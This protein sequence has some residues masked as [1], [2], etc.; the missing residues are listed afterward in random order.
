MLRSSSFLCLNLLSLFILGS[1]FCYLSASAYNIIPYPKQLI[2][3]LGSFSINKRTVV[4]CS[5]DNPEVLKLA[6]QFK[7]QFNLVSGMNLSVHNLASA[8]TFNRIVF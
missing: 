7:E 6:T 4:V 1:S 8:D 2:P 5:S 3:E